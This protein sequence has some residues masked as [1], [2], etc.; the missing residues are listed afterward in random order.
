MK[1]K[2]ILTFLIF[3]FVL[4]YNFAEIRYVSKTGTSTPPYLNGETASDS[5]QKAI[6]I[7]NNGDTV[8][9]ANGV[10]KEFLIIDST[11]TLLGMSMN[12]TVI[13]GTALFF[14]T[15]KSNNN[16]NIG[17]LTII[18][19]S[20]EGDTYCIS[21]IFNNTNAKDLRLKNSAIAISIGESSG[22]IENV[23]VTNCKRAIL[24]FCG[25][26]TCKPIIKNSVF[27]LKNGR[28]AI[29]LFDGGQPVIENNILMSEDNSL[30]QISI[31]ISTAF[32][33]RSSFIMNNSIVRFSVRGIS[34]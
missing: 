22:T 26:D 23:L 13:D 34:M 5:I 12:S 32:D 1:P 14:R 33:V 21:N 28:Q 10:H 29:S 3:S 24:T 27:I 15:I 6:N 9:V 20:I 19:S 11:I 25:S 18:G 2:I 30:S 7:C 17:N 16:L 8:I 4:T 31:G